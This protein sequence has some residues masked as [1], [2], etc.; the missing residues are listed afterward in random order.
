MKP[1]LLV[2]KL[3]TYFALTLVQLVWPKCLSFYQE[4]VGHLDLELPF[5]IESKIEKKTR[6]TQ[7]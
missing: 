5:I 2:A 1:T 7:S 3:C 4:A 6:D